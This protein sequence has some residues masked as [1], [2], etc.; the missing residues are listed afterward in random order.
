MPSGSEAVGLSANA[1]VCEPVL[2][3]EPPRLTVFATGRERLYWVSKASTAS[4][5]NLAAQL[6]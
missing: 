3:F 5:K 2:E 6:G 1:L 4:I